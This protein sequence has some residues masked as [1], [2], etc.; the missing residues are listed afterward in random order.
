LQRQSLGGSPGDDAATRSCDEGDD[1]NDLDDDDH[2]PT[3]SAIA[4]RLQERCA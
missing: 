2:D 3:R 4:V 1:G